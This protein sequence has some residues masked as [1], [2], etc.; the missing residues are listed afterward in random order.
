MYLSPYCELPKLS[1]WSQITLVRVLNLQNPLWI[2]NMWY[3][4]S[5]GYYSAIE[6]NKIMPFQ[7]H[8]WTDTLS[9]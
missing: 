9:Y 3:L 1:H 6:K 4:Y 5:M 2:K 8:V 7:Q